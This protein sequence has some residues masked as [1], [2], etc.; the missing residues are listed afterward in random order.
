MLCHVSAFYP[1]RVLFGALLELYFLL[2]LV[3][4]GRFAH[5]SAALSRLQATPLLMFALIVC[6]FSRP[7]VVGERE[8][9]EVEFDRLREMSVLCCVI[10]GI[11]DS[12]TSRARSFASCTH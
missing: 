3:C 8:K 1:G 9:D 10:V 4:A 6:E 5:L 2:H 11:L 7:L 12:T